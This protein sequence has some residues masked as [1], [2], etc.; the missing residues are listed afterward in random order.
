MGEKSVP[1]WFA[2]ERDRRMLRAAARGTGVWL[3]LAGPDDEYGMSGWDIELTPDE[4]ADVRDY[5]TQWLEVRAE[6][7]AM[8]AERWGE[9]SKLAAE[10][11]RE[12]D[13]DE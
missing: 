13:G 5:L 10:I 12:A 8:A 4:V 6:G 9:E 11:Q 3:M 1:L 7:R 2:I